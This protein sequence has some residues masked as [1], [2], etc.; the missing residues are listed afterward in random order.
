MSISQMEMN[1]SVFKKVFVYGTSRC[2]INGKWKLSSMLEAMQDTANEHCHSLHVGRDDLV[3]N[4]LVWVLFKIDLQIDR[5][6][7]RGEKVTI[8]SFT[9]GS[10]FKFFPRYYIGLDEK[11]NQIYKAGSLWMLMDKNKRRAVS[12][13]ECGVD[14]PDAKEYEVPIKVSVVSKNVEGEPQSVRY[15]PVYTDIDINGHVNNVRYGDILCNRLGF[16]I[17][18][19]NEISFVSVDYHYEV[20]RETVLRTDLVMKDEEFL[21]IGAF[22]EK[23]FFSI[24]G[25]LRQH[26]S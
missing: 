25:K 11:G 2:D 4:G 5:Y 9:K 10:T 18:A 1:G 20:L 7:Q 23:R 6:P 17:L 19:E 26:G 13:K 16:Q 21:L 8:L 14:L 12:S 3:H 15:T 24:Y 22:Q